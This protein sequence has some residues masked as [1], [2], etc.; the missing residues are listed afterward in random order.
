MK[1]FVIDSSVIGSSRHIVGDEEGF[2]WSDSVPRDAWH[3]TG[4]FKTSR[5]LDTLLAIDGRAVTPVP[6]RYMTMMRQLI[7][8][9]LNESIPWRHV[10]PH[11]EFKI[12]FKNI[13]GETT[14]AFTGL[15][16]DYYET[17]WVPA[18]RVLSSLKTAKIDTAKLQSHINSYGKTIPAI[19]TFNPKRSGFSYPVTYDRF[20]TRTGRLTVTD[21]PNILVLKKECRDIITSSWEGGTICYLDFRALE[22]RIVLA[23]AGRYSCEED[24]YEDI[25]RA[26]F[27]G[28]IPR[29]T[30]KTAIL[31]DLYGIS[32]SALKA[33][34]GISDTKLA[35]FIGAI[36][37]YFGIDSLRT[38]L[39]N[40]HAESGLIRNRFGRPLH[41]PG[42]QDNLLINT[43]AQSTGV[44][45]SMIGFDGI[46][47]KLG[48]DGIR[49]LFV[50][51]DAIIIDVH[52]DRL[53]DVKSIKDIAVTGYEKSFP[54]KFDCV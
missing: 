7:S 30:V 46:L 42:G 2:F 47:Q 45:V 24:L 26:Q 14:A 5:C 49:P 1:R 32:R 11:D 37:E 4:N 52:P 3:M 15:P 6:E 28:T 25:A 17:A 16:F 9:S 10:L 40:E 27:G 53:S 23:E 51:H 13:V 33:R 35:A 50:L 34:L 20:A 39:R 21:G 38:R 22:A 44:D 43:Y 19:E 12:F 18:T 29:D 54:I 31:A 8:G 36:E 41:V 48:T